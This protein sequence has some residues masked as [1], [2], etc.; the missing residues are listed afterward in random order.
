[1]KRIIISLLFLLPQIVLAQANTMFNGGFGDGV[2]ANNYEQSSN[3]TLFNGGTND[4]SNVNNYLQIS[5]E[6]LF[7]GGNNDGVSTT[8]F[9]QQGN[10]T[11]FK[12][13]INDGAIVQNFKQLELYSI[14]SGG[15][16]DGWANTALPLSPLPLELLSFTG[17]KNKQ[18][19]TLEWQTAAEININ[20]MEV[21]WSTNARDFSAIGQV[22]GKNNSAN[23][24]SFDYNLYKNGSN[25]YRLKI[26]DQDGKFVYSNIVKILELEQE[27]TI[28]VYPNPTA[29]DLYVQMQTQSELQST[30]NILSMNGQIVSRYVFQPNEIPKL[31]VSSLPKGNYILQVVT[32]RSKQSIPFQKL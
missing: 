1:M 2:K 28:I 11:L 26:V 29:S 32:S 30:M 31:N 14:F 17:R 18:Y 9:L 25:Y 27:G 20:Y 3:T 15:Q 23:D 4:G 8:S 21:Q 10:E 13:G 24:Y 6:T 16:G 22:T 5:N 7:T 19:H 12:G